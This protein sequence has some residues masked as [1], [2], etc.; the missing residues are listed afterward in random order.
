MAMLSVSVKP[1]CMGLMQ[2]NST[3][4]VLK[5]PSGPQSASLQREHR[6]R[7]HQTITGIGNV[8]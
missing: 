6:P 7:G 4:P 5:G 1:Y 3:L 2:K 8:P